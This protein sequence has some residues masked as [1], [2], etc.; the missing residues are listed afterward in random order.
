MVPEESRADGTIGMK[1]YVKY[2]R[3]GGSVVTL[4]FVVLMNLTAQVNRKRRQP[5]PFCT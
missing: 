5:V 4:L 1:L 3:S 2:L